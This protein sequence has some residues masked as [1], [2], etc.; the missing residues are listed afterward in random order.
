MEWFSRQPHH[1]LITHSLYI[2]EERNRLNSNV[3]FTLSSCFAA[4]SHQFYLTLPIQCFFYLIFFSYFITKLTSYPQNVFILFFKSPVSHFVS[5]IVC[6]VFCNCSSGLHP[7]EEH[8]RYMLCL[9]SGN[10]YSNN[11]TTVSLIA[12]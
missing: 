8:R 3:P 1:Q 7:Q 12:A 11:N 10:E 4:V 9:S 6:L 2:R 5:L